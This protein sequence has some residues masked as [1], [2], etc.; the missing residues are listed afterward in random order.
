MANTT[1]TNQKYPCPNCKAF[2]EDSKCCISC[3]HCM[4]Y[5]HLKCTGL[6]KNILKLITKNK[7]YICKICTDKHSCDKCDKTISS[8][9]KGIYCV[10]CLEF[11]CLECM[12]LSNDEVHK[13]LTTK[14]PYYCTNCYSNLYCPVCENLCED[15]E[16]TEPSIFCNIC[17]KWMHFKCSKLK[18]K[19]FNNL[20]R[21]S[22]PY[23]C[24]NCIQKSLP[25]AKISENS[26][27]GNQTKHAVNMACTQNDMSV[28]PCNLCI[29]CNPECEV[30]SS[31]PDLFRLCNSCSKCKM[32]DMNSFAELTKNKQNDE[33]TIVH[34]NMRS[35]K[36][37]LKSIEEFLYTLEKLPD[38]I[39]VTETKLNEISNLDDVQL[40]GY[41][42]FEIQSTSK[43]GGAGM[44]ISEIYSKFL[45]NRTDLDINLPGECE[46]IFMEINF[47]NGTKTSKHSNKIIIGS[48][49][50][51]PHNNHNEFYDVLSE[52]LSRI[53]T[54]SSIFLFGDININAMSQDSIVKQYKNILLS[55]GLL[56]YISKCPTRIGPTNES[57]IDHFISN[58]NHCQIKAGVIQ[59]EATDH[60]PI[61]GI[62]KLQLPQNKPEEI[63]YRRN[64][65]HNK[66]GQFCS[67]LLYNLQ[68]NT[69]TSMSFDP[70][71]ALEGVLKNIQEAYNETFPLKKL[72]RRARK[73]YRKPWVT[74]SIL[75]LIKVKHKLYK[76]YM[77]TKTVESHEAY[78]KQ[79][80]IVKRNIEQ[81]KRNYYH[82]L[83]DQS[84]N[85]AHKTWNC[86]KRVQNKKLGPVDTFPTSI[87]SEDN[88]LISAPINIANELNE[89]FVHKGPRLASKIKA[90]H[91]SHRKYLGTR[92]PHTMI[93]SRISESEVASIVT[94]LELG[95][96]LGHDGI[97]A[98]VLKWCIPH[99]LPLIT[100]IF[101]EFV[102]KGVYPS[103]LKLARVTALHKGGKKDNA[104]NFRPI[105]ILPQFNKVF[106]KLIHRRLL[107]FLKKYKILSKQQFGFLKNHST[108]HSVTCLYEKLIKN[109]ENQSDSAVLFVDLKA[110]FDTV[111]SKILLDKLNH[112]GIR[113]KTLK[114]LTS[115]LDERKQYIKCNSVE[116]VI[117]TVLCGVPQ[118]S[119]L[120]PLLF[121]LF[122]NDIFNCSSFDP[123]MYADDAALVIS[124]KSLNKLQKRI[125]IESK[126]L[127]AWLSANK[128]TLNYKKKQSL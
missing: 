34:F 21:C 46:A 22:D 55:F 72:S 50:R 87:I 52:K 6:N 66:K 49:Y 36:K 28:S 120:G 106:E 56:N 121:I 18:M 51:H 48:I 32:L 118:G 59:Y 70:T 2:C 68:Q 76:V 108:S 100:K 119:V 74:A 58:L 42:F 69:P 25:F 39:C 16:G 61:F 4:N 17:S 13:Y 38:I 126:A 44:Y 64:L 123:V 60:L 57:T 90:P 53:N 109:I 9:P 85:N 128:L 84:K 97:S 117:L 91:F 41:L 110:A 10:Q 31:C 98:Q 102:D 40:D 19:Q 88:V 5:Y 33:I 80:N 89:H 111:D 11:S 24:R 114:L 96:A 113:H 8:Y 83:F 101:N 127:F 3:D 35:L 75:D 122:I 30:C 71:S 45:H 103:T 7:K 15:G 65:D 79:R 1:T 78:K 81:A 23:F 125:N 112:Y 92:N 20:G 124:A 27:F 26:F 62:G 105:S 54:S 104:D 73:K 107:S 67:T 14:Q 115:Y 86:I 116:S 95:K 47:N 63:F 94:E 82:K 29:E 93:F 43:F 12:P 99:I 37:N 77:V